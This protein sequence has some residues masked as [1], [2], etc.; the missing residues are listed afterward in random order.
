MLSV[1]GVVCGYHR[2]VRV[3]GSGILFVGWAVIV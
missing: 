2:W 1:V 3:C